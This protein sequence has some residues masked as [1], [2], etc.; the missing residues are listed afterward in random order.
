MDTDK[1]NTPAKE[2]DIPDID[3]FEMLEF[4]VTPEMAQMFTT[5]SEELLNSAEHSLLDLKSGGD[6]GQMEA[7]NEA[8]RCIHSFK[9][10]CGFFQ[11]T[12]YEQLSHTAENLLDDLKSGELAPSPEIT[13][14][15]LETVDLIRNGLS[16]YTEDPSQTTLEGSSELVTRLKNYQ[17]SQQ[18]KTQEAVEEEASGIEEKMDEPSVTQ[19]IQSETAAEGMETEP[20]AQKKELPEATDAPLP[21]TEA[22]EP[23][24]QPAKAA[25]KS[26]AHKSIRVDLEK[27][28]ILI[29]L[30]GELVIAESMV[31]RHPAVEGNADE[32]L[33]KAIHQLHRVSA[34]LQDIA[35]SVRMVPLSA[36]F[37]RVN[38]L[39]HDLSIKLKKPVKIELVGENTEVDK[40]VIE[41]ISDPLVHLVRN[42]LDHGMETTEERLAIGKPENGTLRIEAKHES[43]EVWIVISDDGRGMDRFKILEKAVAKGMVT[44]DGS[45][46][47]DDDVHA[48]IFQPGFSTATA[49]TDVSGRG[50]G[51]DVVRS[52]IEKINGRIDLQSTFGVGSTFTLRIPLTM[53]IIEGMLVKVGDTLYTIPILSIQESVRISQEHITITPD[54]QETYR[55]REELVPVLRLY[56][57]FNQETEVMELCD[58]IL[59]VVEIG[60]KS[61]GLF[62]DDIVGQQETVI[63]GLS[64]Y[65]GSSRGISG[66]T[67]LGDGTVSL[68]LDIPDLVLGMN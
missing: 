33:S 53:A 22:T 58:G 59:I 62:V 49:V 27:L 37:R 42:A 16:V 54:G 8:F 29:N 1:E 15:L 48:L 44:G 67:I 7:L 65:L 2:D 50:V 17:D 12:D 18:A 46:M 68:I 19:E 14:V 4:E 45:D 34:D 63:K 51:M 36:T 52:N 35:M 13:S 40:T 9:G 20:V 61:V 23:T 43:G 57:V 56:K 24:K 6:E 32:S 64:S 25:S 47:S 28:D 41:S 38:R 30:V 66:C 10:N 21:V 55:L 39:I 5:E 60:G 11:L 31:T 26:S 3:E